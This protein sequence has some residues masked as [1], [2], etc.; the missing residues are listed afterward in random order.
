MKKYKNRIKR[1]SINDKKLDI[2]EFRE[3]GYLQEVNRR[4]FHPLGLAIAIS[5]DENYSSYEL[6]GIYDNREDLEG[7][8]FDNAQLKL[9]KQEFID[10]EFKKRANKRIEM[11]G[12][13]VQPIN[14]EN[15][16]K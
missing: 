11:F 10:N 9:E 6:S 7:F 2:Q 8:I 16:S 13:I 14:Q 15:E 5:Y 4:F 12:N 3:L 1:E